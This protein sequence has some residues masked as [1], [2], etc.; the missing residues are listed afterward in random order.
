MTSETSTRSPL[1]DSAREMMLVLAMAVQEMQELISRDVAEITAAESDEPTRAHAAEQIQEHMER[2]AEAAD[3]IGQRALQDVVRFIGSNALMLAGQEVETRAELAPLLEAIPSFVLGYLE[4]PDDDDAIS[5]LAETLALPDWP[6]PLAEDMVVALSGA[7]R[8]DPFQIPSEEERATEISAE[9]LILTPQE[10]VNPALWQSFLGEAPEEA[11]QLS[12][13][14]QLIA[15]GEVTSERLR[16]AQRHAHTLKGTSA[17]VGVVGVSTIAHHLEDILE[18]LTVR[19]AAPSKPLLDVLLEAG[20][21]LEAMLEV[22]AE[23]S[24]AEPA[25]F[26]GVAQTVLDWANRIERGELEPALSDTPPLLAPEESAPTSPPPAAASTSAGERVVS[27]ERSAAEAAAPASNAG[28]AAA[29][30]Q[31]AGAAGGKDFQ[32]VRSATISELQRLAGELAIA[33]GQ[34]RESLR[35]SRERTSAIQQ[36]HR[37]L[38]GRGHEIESLIDV[39]GVGLVGGAYGTRA[40][41]HAPDH[42]FDALELEEYNELYS[43]SRALIEE[44]ADARELGDSLDD[45]LGGFTELVVQ[46]DRLIDELQELI[47]DTRLVSIGTLEPRLQRIIRQTCRSTDKQAELRVIG[48]D[49]AIDSD[50]L[51]QLTPALMHVMRNC[52]D[53]GIESPAERQQIGKPAEGRIELALSKRGNTIRMS[54][55]DDG[56]GLDYDAIRASAVRRGLISEE[57]EI[58]NERLARLTLSPNFSTRASANLISGRGV[59]MDV[60]DSVVRELKGDLAIDSVAGSGYQLALEIPISLITQHCLLARVGR[61]RAAIPSGHVERIIGPGEGE[62][63]ELGTHLNYS[64]DEQIYPIDF[65]GRLLDYPD[66]GLPPAAQSIL[67]VADAEGKTAVL[68]DRIESAEELV[69]KPLG[70]FMPRVGAITGLSILGDGSVVPVMEVREL[71]R[72]RAAPDVQR[73]QQRDRTGD[74]RRLPRVLVADDSLS[75]RKAISELL[76]DSGYEVITAR[77]GMEAIE[78]VEERRPDLLLVDLEMPRLNGLELAA[79]LRAQSATQQLPIGMITSRSMRKHRDQADAVGIDRFFTKPYQESDLLEFVESA[80]AAEAR[81]EVIDA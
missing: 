25:Q 63:I 75:M 73:Y 3:S 50:I 57:E 74:S 43:A 44:L 15:S 54:I 35:Q 51:E 53:H 41:N 29:E 33:L 40:A 70:R 18:H 5:A 7:L 20:D 78:R 71:L 72:L 77:D 58:S 26:L 13:A 80:L 14:L 1:P 30:P 11:A 36:Q 22:V 46:Q 38:Q 65:L 34:T 32:R 39:R 47:M 21:T 27:P 6:A 79:H 24:S 8:E 68:V 19:E 10:A 2:I 67:L 60:V 81:G 16:E 23:G 56:R 31:S 64:F 17:M 69:V 4:R 66:E 49:V 9:E 12:V 48:G 55:R 59:G 28:E 45:I 42:P 52:V 37:K 76:A 61:R 62:L